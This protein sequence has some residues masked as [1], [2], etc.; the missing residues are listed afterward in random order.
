M[1]TQESGQVAELDTE[2]GIF[3]VFLFELLTVSL[4]FTGFPLKLPEFLLPGRKF[5]LKGWKF[6]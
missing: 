3:P 4:K 6:R 2:T 1:K 5:V